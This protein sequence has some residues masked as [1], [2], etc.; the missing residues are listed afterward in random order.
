MEQSQETTKS[1]KHISTGIVIVI[2]VVAFLIGFGVFALINALSGK[3]TAPTAIDSDGKPVEEKTTLSYETYK[4]FVRRTNIF[5]FGQNTTDQM[6]IGAEPILTFEALSNL[7]V[8]N[9]TAYAFMYSNLELPAALDG[10]WEKATAEEE[11]YVNEALGIDHVYSQLGY[12]EI[13]HNYDITKLQEAYKKLFGEELDLTAKAISLSVSYISCPTYFP[14]LKAV[15]DGMCG[16]GMGLNEQYTY[17]NDVVLDGDKIYS[18]FNFIDSDYAY[19]DWLSESVNT[20]DSAICYDNFDKQ[21]TA[22]CWIYFDTGITSNTYKKLH[23]YRLVFEKNADGNYIYK[24]AE[25][26]K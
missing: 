8:N 14:E 6:I 26:V 5:V 21:P 1:N 23:N 7:P 22:D 24:T 15:V 17:V 12:Y 13:V 10:K 16:G 20:I 18:Y 2:A 11:K 3:P 25:K 19:G 9:K 4:D